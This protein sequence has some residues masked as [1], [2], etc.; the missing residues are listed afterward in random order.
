MTEPPE[1][2]DALRAML[3]GRPVVLSGGPVVALARSVP[4]VT[5]LTGQRPFLLAHG[6]GTGSLPAPDEAVV[7]LLPAENAASLVRAVH[8]Q[9]QT[10][11]DLPADARAALDAWDPE[12]RAVVLASPFFTGRQIGGRPVIGG[13]RPEWAAL[14][15]KTIADALWDTVGVQRAPARVVATSYEAL[16]SAAR[17]VDR[18]AGT[19]WSGD[20]REG[21]NGGG[22]YVRWVRDDRQARAA[23]EFFAAHCD[24]VRV[25]PFLDGVPCSIHGVVFPDGIAA[26]RPVEMVTLRRTDGEATDQFVYGGMSTHWD[27]AEP[28]RA[29]MRDAARR[30]AAGLREQVGYLGGFSVDGVLTADGFLP[31]ELNPRFSGG[32]A[33][34]AKGLPDFPLQLV[35]DAVVS[36]Y[37]VGL[38]AAQFESLLVESADAHRWGGAGLMVPGLDPAETDQRDIIIS[39]DDV[40]LARDDEQGH[41]VLMLGPSAVGAYLRFEPDA[42]RVL[43]GRTLAPMATSA[44]ALADATWGTGIG[45]LAPAPVVRAP[46]AA[47]GGYR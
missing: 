31:T 6:L 22:E 7:H 5:E 4:E 1:V 24:W 21:F 16:T 19:V 44:F 11:A 26:L 45:A 28:D 9:L 37:D 13:R 29:V 32:L 36:G 15:D 23:S 42:D 20:A 8:Q 14:E 35:L 30:V 18:G 12:R 17:D 10:L 2:R 39:G 40:R 47:V 43:P 27:P 25:M 3:A 38:T 33:A 46:G 41:G 34:I